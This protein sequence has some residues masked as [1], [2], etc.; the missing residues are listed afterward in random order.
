MAVT[1]GLIGE[2]VTDHAVIRQILFGFTADENLLTTPLQP[3]PPSGQGNWARV[4]KYCGSDSFK[5][6]F[7]VPESKM[8]LHIDT[9]WLLQEGIPADWK[10]DGVHELS[11][12]D[13][14]TTVREKLIQK[15]GSAFYEKYASR[16]MFAIAVHKTECWL[17][18]I[19]Y[20][21]E[22]AGATD[23]CEELLHAEA[24]K[25]G[26][27]SRNKKPQDFETMCA[28]FTNREDLEN[29]SRHNPSF[30]LFLE[31]LRSKLGEQPPA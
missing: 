26:I 15:I 28:A 7:A 31:E 5:K 19:F 2:G 29:Y 8:V 6:A 10:I 14:V 9:D 23:D 27:K 30:R 12:A 18:S 25:R 4:L 11:A 17:L 3:A 13:L 16:I 1:I 22:K 20:G 21:G 24:V